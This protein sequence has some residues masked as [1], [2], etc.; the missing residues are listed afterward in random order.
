ME[1]HAL[2][3]ALAPLLSQTQDCTGLNAQLRNIIIVEQAAN[4]AVQCRTTTA[5]PKSKQDS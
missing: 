5:Q 2:I 4:P 1:G 3:I